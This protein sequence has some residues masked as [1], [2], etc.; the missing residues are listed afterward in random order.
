MGARDLYIAEVY[1]VARDGQTKRPYGRVFFTKGK[2]LIFY[3]YD[4][5]QQ[6]DA[7]GGACQAWGDEG[8][9]RRQALNLGV[10]YADGASQKRWVLRYDDAK[11]LTQ[12]EA[13]SS[14]SSPTAAAANPVATPPVCRPA[15]QSQSPLMVPPKPTTGTHS[16]APVPHLQ[17]VSGPTR[18]TQNGLLS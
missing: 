14:L 6:V 18:R 1:D 12:I 7:K 13:V 10:F 15:Y 17:G 9:D 11:I 4:L 8:S 16:S 5:D 2:S 3:A